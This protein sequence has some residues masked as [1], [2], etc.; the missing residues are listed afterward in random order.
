MAEANAAKAGRLLKGGEIDGR[1]VYVKRLTNADLSAKDEL[2]DELDELQREMDRLRG[3]DERDGEGRFVRHIDGEI[4]E[5]DDPARRKELKAEARAL[6]EEYRRL[7]AQQLG[8]YVEDEAGASFPAEAFVNAPIRVLTKLI[9]QA[10]LWTYGA[11]DAK[12]P[13]AE[14][15]ASG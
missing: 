8:L 15:T 5:C 10:T 11:E 13:T 1:K 14:R 7:D 9:E 3:R 12:R 4:D 6:A 2:D